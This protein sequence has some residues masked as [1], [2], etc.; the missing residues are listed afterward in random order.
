MRNEEQSRVPGDRLAVRA[1]DWRLV[2]TRGGW[3]RD[4]GDATVLYSTST[5]AELISVQ[6]FV[7]LLELDEESVRNGQNRTRMRAARI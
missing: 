7:K 2:I 5:W 6:A 4:A 1:K 3:V